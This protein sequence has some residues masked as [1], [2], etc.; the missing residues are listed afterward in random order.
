[1]SNSI[2]SLF[3]SRAFITAVFGVI[4]VLVMRYLNV[5]DDVWVSV[6]AVIIIAIS[7][8]TVDDLGKTIGRT[9][10]LTMREGHTEE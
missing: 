7:H 2:V 5:P 9:I 4:T 6:S 8:F 1:M 3:R 10:A